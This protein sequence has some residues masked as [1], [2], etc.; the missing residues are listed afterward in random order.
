MILTGKAGGSLLFC[1]E[2]GFEVVIPSV[3]GGAGE[4]RAASSRRLLAAA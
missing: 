4:G 2:V 1:V 3:G